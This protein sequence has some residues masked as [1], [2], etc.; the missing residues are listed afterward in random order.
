MRQ[1]TKRNACDKAAQG[2]AKTQIKTIQRTSFIREE[3]VRYSPIQFEM[4][5]VTL[6]SPGTDNVVEPDSIKPNVKSM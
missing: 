4:L 5:T 6:F 3:R 2:G 1:K